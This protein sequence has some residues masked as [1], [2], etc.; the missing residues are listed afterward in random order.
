MMKHLVLVFVDGLGW[1]SD[2]PT[3]NPCAHASG[4]FLREL[5]KRSGKR[6]DACLGVPGLP[7][8]A[9][10]QTTLLTGINAAQA[11]NGHLEG[12]PNEALRTIIRENNV[13]SHLLAR[14][15]TVTFA[16]AYQRQRYEDVPHKS[17][18]TVATFSALG[19]VR[20]LDDLRR[21]QAVYQDLTNHYLIEQGHAVPLVSPEQAGENL[22]DLVRQHHFTLF[23]YFQT[24]RAGHT[25][26]MQ[27]AQKVLAELQ[28]FLGALLTAI[29]RRDTLFVLTSDHGNIE[30]LAIKTH[31]RNPVPTVAEG[32]DAAEFL[33]GVESITDITPA[34]VCF[35]NGDKRLDKKMFQ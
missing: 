12:F 26:D 31:T 34:I 30:D 9:T 17:V 11:I 16:N 21:G 13:F 1:G 19:T 4:K 22:A 32:L 23:E 20:G 24:D 29:D 2:D 10:G 25:M 3:R 35:Y 28:R 8:S 27:R 33:A 7:Q 6:T 14:G 15:L 18:T 5:Y